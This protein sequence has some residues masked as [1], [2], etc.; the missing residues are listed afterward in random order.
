MRLGRTYFEWHK[1]PWWGLKRFKGTTNWSFLRLG[2]FLI[3]R[4]S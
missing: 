4:R 2:Y 3:A 1:T